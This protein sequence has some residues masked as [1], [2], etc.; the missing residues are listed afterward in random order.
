MSQNKSPSLSVR[1]FHPQTAEVPLEPEDIS[2]GK[3]FWR[4]QLPHFQRGTLKL[5]R[6]C[7]FPA[8]TT[9][10]GLEPGP[11]APRGRQF[12][13]LIPLSPSHLQ[14]APSG[15][16]V[17]P[18]WWAEPAQRGWDG[19]LPAAVLGVCLC[20]EVVPNPPGEGGPGCPPSVTLSGGPHSIFPNHHFAQVGGEDAVGKI[21]AM[22]PKTGNSEDTAGMFSGLIP[23][24]RP[25]PSPVHPG[26]H[27]Q[28]AG[29]WETQ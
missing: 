22:T 16:Q 8:I 2:D 26:P 28:G 5:K 19:R 12:P 6:A 15:P 27:S 14:A 10:P 21:K 24:A 18:V 4:V 9:E 1:R 25:A 13:L 23:C 7:R 3:G 20:G 11:V 17:W 29:D